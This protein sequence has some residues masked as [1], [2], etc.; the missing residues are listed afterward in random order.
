VLPEYEGIGDLKFEVQ[1]RT[2]LQHAWAELAHDRSFKFGTALPSKIQRKLNL[3]SGLLEIVDGAFDEIAKEVDEYRL[4]LAK[5]STQQISEAEI[6]SISVARFITDLSADLNLEFQD[7]INEKVLTE[8]SQFGLK[9]I[10]D[11]QALATKDFNRAYSVHGRVARTSI[12]LLRDLMMY[13][14]LDK[15]FGLGRNFG[16]ISQLTVTFLESKYSHQAV[17]RW[18]EKLEI[19]V[20]DRP[21]PRAS[22]RASN[23]PA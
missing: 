18:L 23:Q 17:E 15:Y 8:L 3:Y 21:K 13:N 14:D 12:G 11:L 9:N 22:K 10:G 4:S 2:V 7:N 5:K 19:D 20:L 6:N 16:G 1:I